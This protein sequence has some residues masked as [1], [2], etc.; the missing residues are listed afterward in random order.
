MKWGSCLITL[1]PQNPI[2]PKPYHPKT[3]SPQNPIT[4]SPDDRLLTTDSFSLF[5][6]RPHSHWR[7][8][9]RHCRDH[10]HCPIR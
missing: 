5:N 1:S 9:L 10:H 6:L 3:L 8:F 2:T 4:L 7:S